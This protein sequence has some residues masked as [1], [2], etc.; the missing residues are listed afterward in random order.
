VE[1]A[2]DQ[3]RN[4][5]K[6]RKTVPLT[7]PETSREASLRIDLLG[8]GQRMR[9]KCTP[10]TAEAEAV[11]VT[12]EALYLTTDP[13]HPV[14]RLVA[15]HDVMSRPGEAL[16]AQVEETRKAAPRRPRDTTAVGAKPTRIPQRSRTE[17]RGTTPHVSHRHLGATRG[18]SPMN[19]DQN[20]AL[21]TSHPRRGDPEATRIRVAT[22]IGMLNRIVDESRNSLRIVMETGW[23]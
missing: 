8:R 6:G 12:V 5:E 18:A 4:P 13:G 22:K 2:V 14:D 10:L 16:W 9:L 7:N 15:Y 1:I 21:A 3:G 11:L 23:N 20:L 19:G 17:V